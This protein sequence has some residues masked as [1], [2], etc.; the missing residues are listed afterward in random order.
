MQMVI[1]IKR[2]GKL[3][4]ARDACLTG[5]DSTTYHLTALWLVPG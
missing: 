4:T 5:T 3:S 2:E 1:A